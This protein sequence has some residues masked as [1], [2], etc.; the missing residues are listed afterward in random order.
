[1]LQ[2]VGNMID[3]FEHQIAILS[4]VFNGVL[5]KPM[6]KNFGKRDNF[7]AVTYARYLYI[8]RA[9]CIVVYL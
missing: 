8:S 9:H 3:L 7:T 5:A 2:T 6:V 1:M 4:Q